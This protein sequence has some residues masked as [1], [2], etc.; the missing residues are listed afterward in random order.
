MSAKFR[1]MF[2]VAMLLS[3]VSCLLCLYTDMHIFRVID[4][5]FTFLFVL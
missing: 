2:S 1:V 3:T 5:L 4:H